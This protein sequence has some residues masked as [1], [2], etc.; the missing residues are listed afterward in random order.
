MNSAHPA[1][2]H[3][4]LFLACLA[5]GGSYA[6]GRYGLSEGSA[7]WLTLWR[8]GPGALFFSVYLAYFWPK[9][10]QIVRAHAVSISL[11]SV[12]G[13][14]IYPATLFLAVANTTALNASLYLAATPVLILLLSRL[15][16]KEP[17]TPGRLASV[18]FGLAGAL[19]LVFRG[20]WHAFASFRVATSDLWAIVSAISWAGG[21]VALIE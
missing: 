14:V 16:W 19:I 1:F 12:L 8:W 3:L 13:I 9:I 17:L 6:V 11:I 4:L 15:F 20:D 18:V 5:W 21:T 7:L 10:G 2:A